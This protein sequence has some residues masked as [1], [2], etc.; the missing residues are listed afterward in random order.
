MRLTM[1]SGQGWLKD[2]GLNIWLQN[3]CL[4]HPQ[5]CLRR[6]AAWCD[7]WGALLAS[8]VFTL[9]KRRLVWGVCPVLC[10]CKGPC[11]AGEC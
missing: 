11:G 5:A 9:G 2:S 10:R 1:K 7:A 8:G 6:H 4:F 3:R